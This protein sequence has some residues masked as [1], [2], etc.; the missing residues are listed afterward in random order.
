[1]SEPPGTP[2]TRRALSLSLRTTFAAQFL[3]AV[4][5]IM[6]ARALGVENRGEIAAAMLWP[7]V[8]AGIGTL[9]LT[10]SLTFHVAASSRAR[11]RA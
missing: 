11:R 2:S 4:S 1:M 9:G 3:L 8:I 5:G 10:E 6:L 7:T